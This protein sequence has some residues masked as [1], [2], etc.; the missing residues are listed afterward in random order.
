MGLYQR[1]TH[2]L[3]TGCLAFAT[4][5]QHQEATD[6]GQVPQGSR[7]CCR[8]VNHLLRCEMFPL[9][10]LSQQI[11]RNQFWSFCHFM[12]DKNN[13]LGIIKLEST[14]QL[15]EHTLF[16]EVDPILLVEQFLLLSATSVEENHWT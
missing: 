5:L 3:S 11:V 15:R 12:R 14:H 8:R 2:R 9:P 16:F 6:C 10:D 7:C 4:H 1:P 13:L